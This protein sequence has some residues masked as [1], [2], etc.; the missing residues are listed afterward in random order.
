[1][2]SVPIISKFT[3][4]LVS[5]NMVLLYK[6]LINYCSFCLSSHL[7]LSLKR[8]LLELSFVPTNLKKI[9]HFFSGV[10]MSIHMFI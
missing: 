4:F 10:E 7:H 5:T 2:G 8:F 1:M 9:S 3:H 6:K